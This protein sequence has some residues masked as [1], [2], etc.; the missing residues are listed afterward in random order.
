MK[1]PH[2]I[3]LETSRYCNRLCP[4]CP[5]KALKNR[6]SQELLPWMT[7]EKVIQD[8]RYHKY[9]GWLAFHNYNEPL[10]NPRILEEIEHAHHF[11]PGV[12]TTIYTNGDGLTEELFLSLKHTALSQI[13][14][15]LYPKISSEWEA[16]RLR[17]E[18]WLERRPYMASREW[19][20]VNVRQ[21]L[22]FQSKEDFDILIISPEVSRYYDRG[23]T[24]TWL[25]IEERQFPCHL[26]A[27]SLSVDY[28]GN[29]KMCCNIVTGEPSHDGYFFGN[30]VDL[31]LIA[32]WNS[33]KFSQLR[34][35]H[36]EANW[37]SSTICRTCRQKLNF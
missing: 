5:N 31:D 7:F 27:N 10:S 14:V 12:S 25:S 37:S 35:L 18:T 34:K 9:R 29:I 4:W 22:A 13:R 21:G 17:I 11:L 28:K 33:N 6:R 36:A 2:Y 23:S 15:T 26:T 20:T 24:V 32:V 30:V 19:T 16:D 1:L 3:E 8:L